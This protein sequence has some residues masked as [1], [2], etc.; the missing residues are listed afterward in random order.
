[1]KFLKIII[2]VLLPVSIFAWKMESGKVILPATTSASGEWQRVILQQ[3][4]ET[5]PLIFAL[6]DE[7]TGYKGDS[8]VALRI[9]NC[10]GRSTVKYRRYRR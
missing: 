7:G 4:Y 6:L 10:T 8:P 3:T 1:V 9:R 2:F 5:T